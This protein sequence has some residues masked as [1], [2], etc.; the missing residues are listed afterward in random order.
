MGI[1]LVLGIRFLIMKKINNEKQIGESWMSILLSYPDPKEFGITAILPA[2]S[3]PIICERSWTFRDERFPFAVDRLGRTISPI[4]VITV[5]HH[6]MFDSETQ[7]CRIYLYRR[8]PERGKYEKEVVAS[9]DY[10]RVSDMRRTDHQYSL[11]VL[12]GDQFSFGHEIFCYEK[13][14]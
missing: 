2:I 7:A 12:D 8:S 6:V 13:D 3:G 9:R 5:H 4:A 1:N 10:F 11:G 14:N